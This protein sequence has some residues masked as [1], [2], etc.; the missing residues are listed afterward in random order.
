MKTFTTAILCAMLASMAAANFCGLKYNGSW[1]TCQGGCA[2]DILNEPKCI[3]PG[4]GDLGDLGSNCGVL[5]SRA[6]TSTIKEC[7]PGKGCGFLGS[8]GDNG[9]H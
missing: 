3:G 9:C 7:D 8:K 1:K 4:G 2:V 6:S 5:K